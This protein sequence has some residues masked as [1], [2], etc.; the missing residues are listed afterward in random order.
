MDLIADSTAKANFYGWSYDNKLMLYASN[1][2]DERFYDLYKV[3]V[4]TPPKE[5]NVYP[6]DM[7]YENKEGYDPAT[8]SNDNR[9]IAL[10]KP[11]TTNNNDMYIFDT[12]TKE[13][14]HIS[15]HR[16]MLLIFLNTSV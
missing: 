12:Q 14:K 3:D 6:S 1:S 2:R 9:D 4:S 8:V 7:M 5:G 16:E 10:T 15:E 13:M 11:F